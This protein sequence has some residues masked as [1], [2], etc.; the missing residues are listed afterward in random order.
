MPEQRAPSTSSEKQA[1]IALVCLGMTG[2]STLTLT[3]IW[4]WCS[5]LA[6]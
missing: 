1:D 6:E 4:S 2:P 3:D 5:N